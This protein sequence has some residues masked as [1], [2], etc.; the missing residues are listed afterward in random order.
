M[1]YNQSLYHAK[2][3][4]PTR[5]NGRRYHWYIVDEDSGWRVVWDIVSVALTFL[6][7]M[8]EPWIAAFD[9]RGV[10]FLWQKESKTWVIV[11]DAIVFWWFVFD[12]LIT[13]ATTYRTYHGM[14]VS[15]P[16]A[17]CIHYLR[18]FFLWDLACTVPWEHFAALVMCGRSCPQSTSSKVIYNLIPILRTWRGSKLKKARSLSYRFSFDFSDL[19]GAPPAADHIARFTLGAFFG[20]H[21]VACVWFIIGDRSS[22]NSL[23]RECYEGLDYERRGKYSKCTWYQRGGYSESKMS[24]AFLYVTCLYWAVTT[25]TTVGYGDITPV[26]AGE[27]VF[28]I[29]IQICGITWFASLV[30]ALSNDVIEDSK[31]EESRQLKLSLKKFLYKHRFPSHLALAVNSYVRH[32]FEVE[33]EFDGEDP[34][35]SR[36]LKDSLNETLKRHVALHM[37]SRDP[38]LTRNYFFAG[39]PSCYFDLPECRDEEEGAEQK[40]KTSQ[41]SADARERC[42]RMARNRRISF[43]TTGPIQESFSWGRQQ[44]F[45][46]DCVLKM[47]AL[48]GAPHEMVVARGEKSKNLYVIGRGRVETKETDDFAVQAGDYFGEE[49]VLINAKWA[50]SL[51][52]SEMYCEFSIVCQD[53]LAVI[54]DNHPKVAKDVAAETHVRHS[55]YPSIFIV[56]DP[57]KTAPEDDV[58]NLPEDSPRRGIDDLKRL[59]EDLRLQIESLVSNMDKKKNGGG[60]ELKQSS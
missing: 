38:H 32:Q 48:S 46:A 51:F 58:R 17:I 41:D 57:K 18:G 9:P 21:V 56:D 35:V 33:R 15:R 5:E 25:V 26:T 52:T 50:Q 30:S 2:E 28:T 27:K 49:A 31:Y 8:V 3:L 16:K 11:L 42:E 29:F 14:K 4:H 59:A 22:D 23:S 40:K 7:L 53:D 10:G 24:N 37:A 34:E 43:F 60:D 12:I 55:L 6:M 47:R 1:L 44:Y 45:V 36:L 13:F 20:M 19:I 39:R 54:F